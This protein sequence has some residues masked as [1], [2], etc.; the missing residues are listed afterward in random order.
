M[1]K[2]MSI[3][4]FF[5]GLIFIYLAFV[6]LFWYIKGHFGKY[7]IFFWINTAVSILFYINQ[8]N[9]LE[10]YEHKTGAEVWNEV[11]RYE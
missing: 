4:R 8:C 5:K 10:H 1:D 11:N 2:I 6:F 9:K 3:L 7:F